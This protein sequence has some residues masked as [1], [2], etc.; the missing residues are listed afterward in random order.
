[1]S[2][3]GKITSSHLSR[4]AVIYVRQSTLAQ[5]E[6][7]TEST[8]R[9]YDLVHRARR[10]GWPREAIR[11]IDG[12][13]GISGSVTGQRAGFEGMVAEVA[14]GQVGIILA[15]EA[16]RLARDNAAW[17]RLLDLAGVCDTLVA[18]ADG[19]YH[20]AL[21]GDRLL[22]G[23]MG[24]MSE[25]ELHVLRARLTGGIRNKAARGELRR[26]LPAGLIWGEAA[27]RALLQ[28]IGRGEAE[29]VNAETSAFIVAD[30]WFCLI[31][32]VGGL[33][34]GTLGYRF[35]VRRA[36]WVAAAGLMVGAVAAA[37][38]AVWAG[39]RVGLGTYNHLLAS[40]ATGT[41]FNASLGLGAKSALASWP[42]FTSAV[43][44]LG[45][46]GTRRSAGARAA[47][48]LTGPSGMRTSGP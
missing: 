8:A 33:V 25:A 15:L 22:L 40:S 21:F 46:T 36:G 23:L 31:G 14:L 44:L 39:E 10:L 9:Q 20:P 28:E 17:Y 19:V 24:I 11:V 48:D 30:A 13:L 47:A 18:D 5:L 26:G 4:A 6:R 41:Y 37:L 1:M 16:S 2:D 32:A 7:N 38:V 34:T 35:L 42:L 12:D 45:E 3:S 29:Q 27:P 43:I